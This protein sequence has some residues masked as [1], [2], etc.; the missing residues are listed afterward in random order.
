V[1]EIL[2]IEKTD[3]RSRVTIITI[4]EDKQEPLE[5]FNE[6]MMEVFGGRV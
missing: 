2:L 5:L 3:T 1:T 4:P 6:K